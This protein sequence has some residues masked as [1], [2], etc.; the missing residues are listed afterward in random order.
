MVRPSICGGVPV[1]NRPMRRGIP[2]DALPIYLL[3]DPQRALLDNIRKPIWILPAKKVP[4]VNTTARA[5]N[6]NPI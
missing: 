2:A 1:F 3:Q 6:R 4:T 5:V